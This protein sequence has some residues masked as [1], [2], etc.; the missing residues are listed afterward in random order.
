MIRLSVSYSPFPFKCYP[1][2]NIDSIICIKLES[3]KAHRQS[4]FQS[5]LAKKRCGKIKKKFTAF[6]VNLSLNID[7]MNIRQSH[8]LKPPSPDKSRMK[9]NQQCYVTI[10][11]IV[12]S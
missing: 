1:M 8:I 12:S 7:D 4:T 5:A 6:L 2:I 10:L 11:T 3:K 9:K